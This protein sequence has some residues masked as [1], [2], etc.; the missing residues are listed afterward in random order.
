MN[1]STPQINKREKNSSMMPD[2]DSLTTAPSIKN[3][4]HMPKS[5]IS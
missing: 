1:K 3:T 4:A 5:V 2:A